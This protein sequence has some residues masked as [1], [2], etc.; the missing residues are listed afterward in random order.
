M[1][2]RIA[3]FALAATTALSPR[4]ARAQ[5]LIVRPDARIELLSIVYHVA[6][7]QAYNQAG[8]A[9]YERDVDAAF[10]RFH[11]HPVARHARDLQDSLGI[12]FSDPME[13]ALH[14]RDARAPREAVSFDQRS[15]WRWPAPAARSFLVDLQQFVRD[16]QPG[17]FLRSH[18]AFYDTAAARLRRLAD[19][20]VDPLWLTRFFGR[21]PRKPFVLV[22]A[23]LN[24][25]ANYG[26]SIGLPDGEQYYAIIGA[27]RGDT[28][29]WPVF[30][31]REVPVII[32]EFSHSFANPVVERHRAEFADAGPRVLDAVRQQMKRQAY[33]DW[34]TVIDE[35]LVRVTVARYRFA[36]QGRAAADS[37]IAEERANG[38]VWMRE[39]YD[40]VGDYE[41]DRR[42]Y[43]DLDAFTPRIADYWKSLPARLPA[44]I[45]QFDSTRPHLVGTSPTDGATDVDP[46]LTAI[47]LHFDRP[48]RDSSNIYRPHEFST[49]NFPTPTGRLTFDS[50]R[51]T[52]V[53]PVHLER[54]HTYALAFGGGAGFTTMDGVGLERTIL[55]FHVKP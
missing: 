39:L 45:A 7:A 10:S 9:S 34:Q 48:V 54:G 22:A 44:L 29:G 31:P 32:H 36:H 33:E 15:D 30:G 8:L 6:G 12:G 49:A 43:P 2:P 14:L 13:F 51:T 41:A 28:A 25:G 5:A 16:A 17:T 38:F 26:V 1:R 27:W 50:S 40:L 23:P 11:D 53:I 19:T 35:S 20:T 3:L 21:A 46:S 24:G 55:H 18:A 37:Q 4:P 42:R 52:L 47:T